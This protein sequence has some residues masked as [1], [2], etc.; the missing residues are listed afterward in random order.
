VRLAF[1]AAQ[2]TTRRRDNEN[3]DPVLDKLFQH[4]WIIIHG[5]YHRLRHNVCESAGSA[6]INSEHKAKMQH[7][8]KF[9]MTPL[10]FSLPFYHDSP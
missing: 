4:V 3:I 7:L 5:P 10:P 9:S 1:A 8:H 6:P 2:A